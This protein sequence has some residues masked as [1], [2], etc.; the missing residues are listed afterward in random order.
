[1]SVGGVQVCKCTCVSMSLGT[2]ASGGQSMVM[3][4]G[5]RALSSLFLETGSLNGLECAK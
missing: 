2:C 5:P 1:M 3:S 4:V